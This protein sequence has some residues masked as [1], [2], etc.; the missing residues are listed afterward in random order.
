MKENFPAL[1][2]DQC[3]VD[4]RVSEE[5]HTQLPEIIEQIIQSCR[6]EASIAHFD[7]ALIPSRES[8]IEILEDLQDLLFPGYFRQQEIDLH[9]LKY[10]IGNE[11]NLIFEKLSLQIARSIRHECRRLHSLCTLCLDRGQADVLTF[12]RKIPEIRRSLVGDVRA[13]YDGDPAAK[14][15]DEVIFSYPSI[16]AIMVY[17]VAHEL[18]IQGVP[19]LPRIMTEYAHSVTGIDIHPGAK[20]GKDFF[21]DHG[22]GVVIG[23]TTEIG[24][25]VKI[26]QGVTLGALSFPRDEQGNLI[27]GRKRHPTIEDDVTIYSNAT[28]LGPTVIGARSVIGGNVWITQPIPPDTIVSIEPPRLQVKDGKNGSPEKSEKEDLA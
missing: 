3:Q 26:Y 6:E 25:R 2:G 19:L 5:F 24:D 10:H 17:R 21:I 4:F 13:A 20:I 16:L 23:E 22:T 7:T 1:T 27:R 9:S 14:N 11:V 15:L 18:H 8:V 12:L 28:I